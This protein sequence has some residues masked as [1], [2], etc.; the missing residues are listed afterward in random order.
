MALLVTHTAILQGREYHVCVGDAWEQNKPAGFV[1]PKG[2][3]RVD[4]K[5]QRMKVLAIQV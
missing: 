4:Q 1:E 3:V 2:T 5:A